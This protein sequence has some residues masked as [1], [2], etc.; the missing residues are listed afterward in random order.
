MRNVFDQYSQPENKL[1]HALCCTLS[2]DRSL[3]RPFLNW[4]GLRD[5]PA[6]D[7]LK[8]VQ[9]HIPGRRADEELQQKTVAGLPDLMIHTDDGWAVA[10]EA[11]VTS[12]LTVSQLNRHRTSVVKSGFDNPIIV[13]I[14]VEP[15]SCV[16]PDGTLLVLWTDLHSWFS[17][18]RTSSTWARSFLEYMELF[19]AR[20]DRD[21]YI[22]EGKLT[23]FDG[24]HFDEKTPFT[25][26]SGK[27]LLKKLGDE[28]QGSPDLQSSIGIDA[29]GKRRPAI[30]DDEGVWDFIPLRIARDQDFVRFPHLTMVLRESEAVA[31]IVVPNGVS[32]GFR[33]RLKECGLNEF[34]ELLQEIERRLRPVIRRSED[35]KPLIYAT[36]RHYLSQKSKPQI[37]GLLKADLRTC[38][39]SD[40]PVKYQPQWIESL[41]SLL[42]NKRSNIQFGIDVEFSYSCPIVQTAKVVDLFVEAWKAMSPLLEL[43][44]AEKP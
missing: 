1:T 27:R 33:T 6:T 15:P 40:S 18:R 34:I 32:G 28:L 2:H 29:N 5:I 10:F 8:V 4:L 20:A 25:Y 9:Q 24:L 41:F 39:D 23:M 44:L 38:I 26:L 13:A 16:L 22:I 17:Q 42:V 36:Q 31:A 12:R 14:T 35:S 7:Q 21:K 37:D 30:T 3:L 11:K 19:E 43:V